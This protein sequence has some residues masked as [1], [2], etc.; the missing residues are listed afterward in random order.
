MRYYT[1]LTD[2]TDNELKEIEK[3]LKSGE[4][5]RNIK[6]ELAYYITK[7]YCGENNANSAQEDFINVVQNH[8]APEDI[9]EINAINKN[10]LDILV[11]K[12]FAKSK[13]DAKRLIQQGAV[14]FDDEKIDDIN[15]VVIKS[16]II[17]SGKRNY[18][19][20]V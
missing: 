4:N 3:R 6:M 2:K 1:L 8:Q 20:V 14:K 15:F 13:S 12:N 18:V 9:E 16:G 7:E 17:K 5:P 10:I 19:K 11:E